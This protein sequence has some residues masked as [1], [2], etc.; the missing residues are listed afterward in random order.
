MDAEDRRIL[1]EV[2]AGVAG[3]KP[4]LDQH[5]A[6][7]LRLDDRTRSL[8]TKAVEG[9]VKTERLQQDL[10]GLGS[11]VRTIQTAKLAASAAP[12]NHGSKWL[13]LL[14]ILANAPKWAHAIIAAGS[15]ATLAATILWQH[16]PRH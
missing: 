9:E 15:V 6:H 10:N 3:L 4:V 5:G 16:W 2:H 11:K 14:E 13:A 12:E 7:L 8:E 1:M